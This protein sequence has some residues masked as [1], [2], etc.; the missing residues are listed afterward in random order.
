M[1]AVL[2]A[3]VLARLV[4]LGETSFPSLSSSFI[5]LL[6]MLFGGVTDSL[7]DDKAPGISI[8]V[9]VLTLSWIC[10]HCGSSVSGTLTS[11]LGLAKVRLEYR[12][13]LARQLSGIQMVDMVGQSQMDTDQMTLDSYQTSSC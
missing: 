5:Q 7:L 4:C 6:Y 3:E 9:V 2:L 11:W 12:I 13:C 1:L 10:F 8:C